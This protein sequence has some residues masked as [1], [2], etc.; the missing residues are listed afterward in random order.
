MMAQLLVVYESHTGNTRKMAHAVAEGARQVPGVEVALRSLNEVRTEE[1]AGAEGIIVG[2]PTRN[3]KVPPAMEQFLGRLRQV[4]VTG[5]LGA[6]FGSYGW[7]GEAPALIRSSL[8]AQGLLVPW[9]G[10]RAKRAP[11]AQA[12]DNC[13]G[14]GESVARRL[15]GETS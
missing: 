11:D 15:V 6:S 7:S 10:V 14:L 2:A 9:V 13:R 12:L 4:P 3:T 1:L 5:K 8:V